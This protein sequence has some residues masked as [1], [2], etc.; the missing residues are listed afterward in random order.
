MQNCNFDKIAEPFGHRL[1]SYSTKGYAPL[2]PPQIF[3]S[4]C[5]VA[6]DPGRTAE[7][8]MEPEKTESLPGGPVT[9]GVG[10]A[11]RFEVLLEVQTRERNVV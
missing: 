3:D 6:H 4:P 11:A 1:K 2:Q 9:M 7:L 5:Q 10:K 8:C